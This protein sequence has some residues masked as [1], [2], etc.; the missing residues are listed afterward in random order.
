MKVITQTIITL[1][2]TQTKTFPDVWRTYVPSFVEIRSAVMEI[3]G[4]KHTYIH[5]HIH[6]YLY[7]LQKINRVNVWR[8]L[9]FIKWIRKLHNYLESLYL[10]HIQFA[11]R[12]KFIQTF[13][14][15]L[16]QQFFCKLSILCLL[17]LI[18]R[19]IPR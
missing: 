3:I 12:S 10:C 11:F 4:D 1:T 14:H 13:K 16:I 18:H 5:T 15:I 8:K 9:S 2:L 7:R 19:V 6:F 17:Y